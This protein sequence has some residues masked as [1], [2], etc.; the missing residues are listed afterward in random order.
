ME[1][2]ELKKLKEEN[3]ITNQQLAEISGVP[4][5]TITKI[6]CGVTKRPRADKLAAI[7]RAIKGVID[8]ESGALDLAVL[9][10]RKTNTI[11]DYFN[12]PDNTRAEL[13]D[14]E[15]YLMAEPTIWH[16][17]VAGLVHFFLLSYVR[18]KG[19][20]CLPLI[21][22]VGVQLDMDDKTVVEPDVVVVCD[23]NKVKDRVVYGAPDWALEVVSPSSKKRDYILKLQKYQNA[24]VREYWIIDREKERVTVYINLDMPDDMEVEIYSFDEKIPVSIYDDLV[25]DLSEIKG[26]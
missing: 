14:G 25:I 12:L 11:D 9:F 15:F 10:N 13:I 1:I 2:N 7:E 8:D 3:K 21:A 26:Y 17:R 24:G 5:G 6:F 4:Y 20:K 19:G 18:E 16:Q 22:P 23:P